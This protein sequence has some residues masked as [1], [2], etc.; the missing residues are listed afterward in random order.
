MKYWAIFLAF[1]MTIA[2]HAWSNE[3]TTLQKQ[4]KVLGYNPGSADGLWG[5]LTKKALE[6]FLSDQG[7]EYDG[8][9]DNNEFSLIER[10]LKKQGLEIGDLKNWDYRA[11]SIEFGGYDQADQPV[12]DAIKTIKNIPSFGFNVLTIDFKC[13]GKIDAS[14]PNYYPLSRKTG[15]SISYKNITPE[16]GFTSNRSDATSLAIDEAKAKKLAINLKPMFLELGTRFG[17]ADASGYGKIP[18]KTFFEGDGKT[19]SG[20][21][22]IILKLADYAQE[23]R[24]EYLT[25][26]TELKNL[27]NSIETDERWGQLIPQIKQRFS[28][29]LIYAHNFKGDSDLRKIRKGNVMTLVDIVGLNFFPTQILSNK[30]KYSPTD[31]AAALNRAKLKNGRNMMAEASAFAERLNKPVILSETHFPTWVGSANWMFRGN[32]D[33]KNNEREG[34]I[35]TNGP[36]QPKIPSDEYGRILASGFH[37]AFEDKDWV[38]GADYLYWTTAHQFDEKTDKRDYGPCASYLWNSNDGIKEMIRDFH[39]N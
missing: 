19:W 10:Q 32:C 39:S 22:K 31:V 38:Y 5:G 26:G 17:Q 3:V 24:V 18:L 15:C 34:W 20:Y 30:K 7:Q 33:Y 16:E 25:I 37:S 29:K 8:R 12:Y 35:F 6:N 2:T 27:N 4:L 1:L 21:S 11:T 28:G 14:A 23:N 36:L 13:T 9:L